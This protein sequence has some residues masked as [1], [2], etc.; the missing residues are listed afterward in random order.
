MAD[1]HVLVDVEG[2]GLLS[3]VV[4]PHHPPS[5]SVSFLVA[6]VRSYD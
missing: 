6:V 4:R 3:E 2:I 1:A 5:S